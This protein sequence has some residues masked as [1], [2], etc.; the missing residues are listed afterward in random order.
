[1]CSSI[2]WGRVTRNAEVEESDC[3]ACF[4]WRLK[5]IGASDSTKH[6]A[7]S[8]NPMRPNATNITREASNEQ[9]CA[10]NNERHAANRASHRTH[11]AGPSL[12]LN[13]SFQDQIRSDQ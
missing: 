13:V 1:V 4:V 7:A 9:C 5:A 6:R 10:S 12:I 3:V 8:T 2:H 11:A